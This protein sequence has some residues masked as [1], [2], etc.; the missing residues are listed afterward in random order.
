MRKERNL[1]FPHSALYS[2]QFFLRHALPGSEVTY[3]M[4]SAS[5]SGVMDFACSHTRGDLCIDLDPR[6][7]RDQF[8]GQLDAFVYG[9][10]VDL[11]ITAR[12]NARQIITLV[13]R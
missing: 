10:S 9:D 1:L 2:P 5:D 11:L 12:A 8:F 6:V 7:C 3:L 4:E 13:L